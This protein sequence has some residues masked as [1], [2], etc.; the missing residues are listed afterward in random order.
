VSLLLPGGIRV[1]HVW[2][3]VSSFVG[4]FI[5]SL[6]SVRWHTVG[7]QVD[8]QHCSDVVGAGEKM[9]GEYVQGG[10]VLQLAAH[11]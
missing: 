1:C 6:T 8:N 5:R 9:F 10:Y 3:L 7:W 11:T 4:W 2:W